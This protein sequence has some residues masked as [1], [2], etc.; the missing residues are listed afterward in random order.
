M[1]YLISFHISKIA[2]PRSL[3]IDSR[4]IFMASVKANIDI[5]IVYYLI[6]KYLS[7]Y[8]KLHYIFK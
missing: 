7:Q 2:I 8:Q 1:Y 6:L 5:D 4:Q 3:T